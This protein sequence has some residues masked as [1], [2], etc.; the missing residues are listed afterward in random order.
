MSDKLI[1]FFAF[2]GLV[3]A[4]VFA[5]YIGLAILSLV[6]NIVDALLCN[7]RIKHRF[8][9]KPVAKCYCKDCKYRHE[10][11]GSCLRS[12]IN[13]CADNFF[14][15]DAEPKPKEKILKENEDKD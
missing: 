2:F 13:H 3:C 9:K 15:N 7:Y 12:N 4:G 6:T 10:N 5:V 14:C 8:D 1:T 11:N